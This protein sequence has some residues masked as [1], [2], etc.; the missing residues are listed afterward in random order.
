[1]FLRSPRNQPPMQFW[2]DHWWTPAVRPRPRYPQ[3]GFGPA[4]SCDA[5]PHWRASSPNSRPDCRAPRAPS[6]ERS[7]QCAP[8]RTCAAAA[9]RAQWLLKNKKKFFSF[10]KTNVFRNFKKQKYY[11]QF[12]NPPTFSECLLLLH[13]VL[14]ASQCFLL[15][16]RLHRQLFLLPLARQLVLV[17][18]PLKFFET[19]LIFRSIPP[20]MFR[21]LCLLTQRFASLLLRHAHILG[22]HRRDAGLQLLKKTKNKHT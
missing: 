8:G 10:C 19:L 17:I 6:P 14:L 12:V 2:C 20:H 1:M 7:P 15:H 18:G 9:V 21:V 22:V 5:P 13:W 16:A 4:P 11:F 3:C